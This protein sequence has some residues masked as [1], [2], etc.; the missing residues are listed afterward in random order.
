MK[1]G[2]EDEGGEVI[3]LIVSPFNDVGV[4]AG[5]KLGE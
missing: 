3:A 5:I 1:V 4:G 2:T